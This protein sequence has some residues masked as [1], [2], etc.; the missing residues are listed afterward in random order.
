MAAEW[1]DPVLYSSAS[2]PITTWASDSLAIPCWTLAISVAESDS[3][4]IIQVQ[5]SIAQPPHFTL[6]LVWPSAPVTSLSSHRIRS[7]IT[8]PR[9]PEGQLEGPG[10]AA[11]SPPA[12]VVGQS[13]TLLPTH[14]SP[15]WQSRYPIVPL[16]VP[17]SANH[18]Q[19]THTLLPHSSRLVTSVRSLFKE[20]S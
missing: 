10:T 13:L 20:P 6:G 9:D 2:P 8:C 12:N 15:S 7:S 18:P 3:L 14:A 4:V 5:N 1:K 19:T 16:G 17:V 11:T